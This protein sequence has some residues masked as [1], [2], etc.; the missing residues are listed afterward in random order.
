[1]HI[2]IIESNA[3]TAKWLCC[4]GTSLTASEMSDRHLVNVLD[5][6][7]RFSH[8]AEYC[9][10][11]VADWK[12]YF[13]FELERRSTRKRIAELQT[14]LTSVAAKVLECHKQLQ[15]GQITSDCAA[16]KVVTIE[17]E[18]AILEDEL[19]LLNR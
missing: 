12:L 6:L 13:E 8:F 11:P 5:M 14:R 17:D 4:D 2:S 10:H 7:E 16:D 19:S 1:M 3:K 9:D 18:F 15:M